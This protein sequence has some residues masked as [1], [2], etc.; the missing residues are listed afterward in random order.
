MTCDTKSA[1]N[2]F[3]KHV[4]VLDPAE[5]WDQHYDLWVHN[6]KIIFFEPSASPELLGLPSLPG[7]NS[8]SNLAEP[9]IM[10]AKDLW[11]V[12]G[13]VDVGR[14]IT[15]PGQA[16][17]ASVAD[18]LT[19]AAKA[20]FSDWVVLPT[21]QPV[22][23]TPA[24]TQLIRSFVRD[25]N[26]GPRIWPIGALTQQL[27]GLQLSEM[28]ALKQ[29]GCIA[30]SQCG[31]PVHNTQLLL[32]AYRY[33]RNFD[34]RVMSLPKE[35]SLYPQGGV[36]DGHWGTAL[37]LPTVPRCAESIAVARDIELV[38]ETGVPLHFLKIS[39]ADSVRL[40]RDAQNRQLPITCGVSLPHLL[41]TEAFVEGFNTLFHLEPPL[42]ET[43]D[44]VALLQGLE[45]GVISCIVSDHNPH[46]PAAKQVPFSESAPGLSMM[47]SFV[48]NLLTLIHSGQ[49][50][51]KTAIAAITTRPRALLSL[52]VPKIKVGEAADFAIWDAY[53]VWKLD[54]STANSRGN[55]PHWQQS[56]TG[57]VTT[58]NF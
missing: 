46:E 56:L 57:K 4:R 6:G 39:T 26:S 17:K 35:T 11:C 49:L 21:T 43:S 53:S 48:P 18:E 7:S 34:L 55:T 36:H 44:Q 8:I 45:E 3:L 13:A 20:G 15:E 19:A 51:L 2:I 40:I 47:D 32:N 5:C 31:F 24:I 14:A 37:G 33:A 12:P 23:D 29:V 22:N 1:Q 52:P 27:Q 9:A 38:A 16:V 58:V 25:Q 41:Y 54:E 10:E 30:V 28:Y 50:S 42:R